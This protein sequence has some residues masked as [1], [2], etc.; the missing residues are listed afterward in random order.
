MTAS[1]AAYLVGLV[2]EHARGGEDLVPVLERGIEALPLFL[3]LGRFELNE[4]GG[5]VAARDQLAGHVVDVLNTGG[6][7]L[8]NGGR[9]QQGPFFLVNHHLTKELTKQFL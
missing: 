5:I 4:I 8:R 3:E 6:S 1:A 7:A 2:V 9:G